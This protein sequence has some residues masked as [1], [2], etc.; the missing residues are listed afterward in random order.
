MLRRA[1]R[2]DV[3]TVPLVDPPT[4]GIY[5]ITPRRDPHPSAPAL[6]DRLADAF[7]S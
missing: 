6:I 1:L 7:A 2:P 5:A 4:R 3:V